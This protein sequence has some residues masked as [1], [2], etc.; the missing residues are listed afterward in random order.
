MHDDEPLHPCPPV[1]KPKMYMAAVTCQCHVEPP[2]KKKWY[3]L[4][5]DVITCG[6]PG[7]YKR[8]AQIVI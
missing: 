6:P 7:N 2:W 3:C 1:T 4:T 8:K 5:V